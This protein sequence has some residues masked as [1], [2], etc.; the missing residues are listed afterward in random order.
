VD[1]SITL[2]D[3]R[4][5]GYALYGPPSG[6]AVIYLHGFPS[7]RLEFGLMA[8]GDVRVISPDRPGYGLSTPAPDHT[9]ARFADDLRALADALGLGRFALMGLSG[10]APYAACAA[11]LLKERVGALALISGL[12]PPEAPGMDKGRPALL[13]HFGRNPIQRRLAFEAIRAG[14]LKTAADVYYPRLRKLFTFAEGASRDGEIMTP[15]FCADLIACWRE[16]LRQ[17]IEGPALDARL[18]DLPWPIDPHTLQLPTLVWHGDADPVVPPQIAEYYAR[19]LPHAEYR[20][21]PGDGHVSL[22]ARHH[23]EILNWLVQ[24]A[25]ALN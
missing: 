23:G 12:G 18:Y 21:F 24:D 13:R 20:S 22:I 8:K 2:K 14:L 7:C 25:H 11:G 4:Q 15:K 19:T 17:S 5:L 1:N 3:G 10:G 9:F 16:A 6:P